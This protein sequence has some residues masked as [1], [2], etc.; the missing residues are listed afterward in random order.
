VA[1]QTIKFDKQLMQESKEAKFQDFHNLMSFRIRDIIVVSSMY[2]FYLFEEDGRLYE[3]MRKEFQGLNLSNSPELV[4]VSS[5]KEALELLKKEDRFNLI[6][7]TLHVE[8]MSAIKLAKRVKRSGI[9]IPIALLGYSNDELDKIL[10]NKDSDVFDKIFMWQGDFRIIFGIIKYFEDKMNVE[11]DTKS[12]GVQVIILIEDS[13]RF[14]SIYLPLVYT[15]VVKQA[16]HLVAEGINLSHRFLKMRARPKIILCTT[17]EE[18]TKYFKKYENNILGII[19]DFGF[20]R[21]GVLNKQAGLIFTKHVKKSYP[22]LPILLQSNLETNRKR[23]NSVGAS[24]LNKKSAT[25]LE[26]LKAFMSEQFSFGDFIFR[27]PNGDEVARAADLA[28][29]AERLQE[30]PD[31]SLAFHFSRNHFSS[32]LKARTDFWLAYQIRPRTVEQ[33]PTINAMR[34]DLI[35]A[36]QNYNR[37]R[38]RGIISDFDNNTFNKL[39]F[40]ARIGG[41]SIGGKTRGLGFFS[42]LLSNFNIESKFPNVQIFV[43]TTAVLATDIFDQFMEEN[44][45]TKFALKCED[46]KEILKAFLNAAR[47]PYVAIKNLIKFLKV[48]N[49]PLAVRSSSLLEDSQ[50]QPFAGVYETIMIPNNH[51][52][53]EVRLQQLIVAIKQVYASIYSQRA[54]QYIKVTS[55]HLEEEKMAVIIQEMV[56]AEHN[57]KFYP[58][59]SGVAKSY[60]FYP[61]KPMHSED[62]IVSTAFGLG[63]TIVEGG[64]CIQFCPKY[65]KSIVQHSMVDDILEYAQKKYFAIDMKPKNGTYF[66]ESDLVHAHDVHAAE[67]DGTLFWV[68][69]TYSPQTHTIHDGISRD[70]LKLFTLAPILKYKL[71]PLPEILETILKMGSWGMSNPVE[72]EFAINLSV[73]KGELVKFAILQ[74]RPLVINTEQEELDVTKYD[75]KQLICKSNSIL[76]NGSNNRITDIVFVDINEFDR[77]QSREA[78]KDVG[79]FNAKLVKQNREYL[80]I[81]IGRWGTL[82]PWLG[83]PIAWEQIS[84]AKVIVESNFKDF[85]VEPSQGSHFFQNMTSFKVGYF[86]VNSYREKGFID[87]EWLRTQQIREERGAIKHIQLESPLTIKINGRENKGIIIKP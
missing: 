52:N 77:S 83:I 74:M 81:G 85:D 5:G 23:A 38:Q 54:K 47:F 44:S 57:E 13:V 26:D 61:L 4:H 12:V 40:F 45:L 3:L 33:Y 15:E 59:I 60:N 34:N 9:N 75:D 14:Y 65:P 28:E 53:S 82:D 46:D 11:F 25:L 7:T 51:E 84:G 32:W 87:W 49:K 42:S 62:G 20:L 29:L 36:I 67:K 56:G 58:E 50:G 37:E 27:M 30:V 8:D 63:K 78:A 64:S 68:G 86:T 1:D 10:D 24:F 18:A 19:S 41:G 73:P 80:L 35:R 21:K 72:I 69:S 31:E 17:Y 39:S 22:D 16:Q 66:A 71:F 70:G 43:P 55:Y 79:Y 48:I 76:G 6:I 2:D